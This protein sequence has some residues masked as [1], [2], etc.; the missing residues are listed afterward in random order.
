MN[1]AI[2]ADTSAAIGPGHLMRCLVQ[3]MAVHD[4]VP[5]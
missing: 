2:R 1:M 3:A 4:L 5:A